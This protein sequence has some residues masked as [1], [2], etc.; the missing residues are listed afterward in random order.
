MSAVRAL[1]ASRAFSRVVLPVHSRTFSRIAARAPQCLARVRPSPIRA[2]SVTARVQDGKYTPLCC[3]KEIWAP[4]SRFQA[5]SFEWRLTCLPF[6]TAPANLVKALQSEITFEKEAAA[7]QP[8]APEFLEEFNKQGIWKVRL[9]HMPAGNGA[10]ID[11]QIQD[12]PG[13]DEVTLTRQFGNETYVHSFSAF[14]LLFK[15]FLA[16]VSV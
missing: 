10:D 11:A 4:L 15:L 13:Q 7:E 12:T 8:A 16:T 1:Q 5:S 6:D 14:D 2:F 9:E 3:L